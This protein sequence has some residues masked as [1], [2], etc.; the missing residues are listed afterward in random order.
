ML[1]IVAVAR[2]SSD[3]SATRYVFAVLG[4]ISR[5]HII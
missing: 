4:I 1:N 5:F 2:S 3:D